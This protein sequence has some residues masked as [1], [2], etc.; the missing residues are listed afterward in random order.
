MTAPLVPQGVDLRGFAFTPVEFDRLFKSET[1]LLS[2][3]AEKV[4]AITLWGRSWA[5]VPAG[6]LPNDDRMLAHL[7]DAG[8]AWKKVKG[9]ALRN[10]QLASDGR[11]YHPVVCEKALEAW[12]EKLATQLSSG[13][14]NA[15][16]WNIEFDPAPIEAAIT[17][18]RQLLSNLNPQ[19][20]QLNK[21]RPP[22]V[23]LRSHRES[24]R[25]SAGSPPG[26][27]L[28]SQETETE[29]ETIEA[30]A[31]AK[32]AS[33]H[34]ARTVGSEGS[35]ALA[36]A[37]AGCGFAACSAAHPDLVAADAEGITADE[38]RAVAKAKPGKGIAYLVQAARGKRADAAERS[39][40]SAAPPPAPTLSPEAKAEAEAQAHCE[41]LEL[42]AHNDHRLKLIT[43][44]VRDQRIADARTALRWTKSTA[45]A[46][47]PPREARA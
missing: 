13:A 39:G 17:E 44:A 9:M 3:S 20:R 4:A 32:A 36:R 22:G 10:W 34:T 35:A 24:R 5:Q 11:M 46:A 8:P 38:L 18:A 12:L 47:G 30:E 27:P 26:V 41:D 33:T 23:P 21:R 16:R 40:S 28:R 1:W 29:T 42:K 14:G 15:K 31:E 6:S 43:A 19:S 7:S 45:P 37:L 2:T 25:E